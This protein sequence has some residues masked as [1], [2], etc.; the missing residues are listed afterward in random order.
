MKF[1]RDLILYNYFLYKTRK[2][3]FVKLYHEIQAVFNDRRKFL[4]LL[5]YLILIIGSCSFTQFLILFFNF[6]IEFRCLRK[7]LFIAQ[8]TLGFQS[9][10]YMNLFFHLCDI[11]AD[12]LVVVIAAEFVGFQFVK[13]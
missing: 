6:C 2:H 9:C 11:F 12:L 4:D 5:D 13:L 7:I 8:K 1:K 10:Q 3:H